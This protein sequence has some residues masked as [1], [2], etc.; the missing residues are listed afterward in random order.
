MT[1]LSRAFCLLLLLVSFA[2]AHAESVTSANPD[3][4]DLD[5][6]NHDSLV[7]DP[8]RENA[9]SRDGL[10]LALKHYPRPGAQPI[11]LIH[12][13]AQNDRGWDSLV[14]RYSFAR[15][16]HSQGFDVWMGNLR[17]AGTPG[18]RSE[19]PDGPHHWTV[20]D[21][22]INDMPS[23]VEAVFKATG[24]KPFV[25]VH[26]LGAWT[27]EGYLAGISY[28][29]D[30][31]IVAHELGATA[32]QAGIRGLV[33]IAGVYN[34]RWEHSASEAAANPIAS[35]L[36]YYHSNYELELAAKIRPL[37]HVIPNLPALPLAWIN[38]VLNVPLDKIPFIGHTLESLYHG[39]QAE[40]IGS[41]L[42]SMFCY[43][44]DSD[45]EMV[46]LHARDG[47]E[48]MGPHVVEQLAN[49]IS[50]KRTSSYYH[51]DR[52][53]FVYN[54]ASV[55]KHMSIPLLFVGGGR[56]RLASSYEIYED[57]YLQTQASDK[58]F[59]HVEDFGHLDIVTGIHAPSE[60]MMPIASWIRDRM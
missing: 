43:P 11:L 24:Q 59:L 40:L 38:D 45:K 50:E 55:H 2:R 39:F 4:W 58:Q 46:R 9:M 5:P 14:K 26:S 49:A 3:T 28:D 16:M 33:S 32:R 35:E 6:A 37:Y 44:P 51:I 23:L 12:G 7:I 25:I 54:Y 42:M 18:F 29:R 47:L 52:P 22:A 57:G 41:P 31:H 56:D 30:G 17:G 36:D 19:M 48:D 1:A 60:V 13:L 21:Y 15:F 20:D 8:V 27:T 34:L 53:S 10:R